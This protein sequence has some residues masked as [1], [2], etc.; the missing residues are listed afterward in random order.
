MA[1]QAIAE[2]DHAAR[3][4]R[5]NAQSYDDSIFSTAASYYLRKAEQGEALS[6]NLRSNGLSRPTIFGTR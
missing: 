5:L 2:L 4:D 1:A 3:I 6:S